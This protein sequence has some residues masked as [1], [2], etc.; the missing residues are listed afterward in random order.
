MTD[1]EDYPS[2]AVASSSPAS[3]SGFEDLETIIPREEL[4]A[5]TPNLTNLTKEQTSILLRVL[6]ALNESSP[7]R[8]QHN[9]C[10][11][12][13]R[14]T[15]KMVHGYLALVIC[16]LGV[17]ANIL[18]MIIFTRREMINSTNT[19]LT[20]LAVA[21]FLVL[22]EYTAFAASYIRGHNA[23]LHSHAHTCYILFH[24]H[25]AQVL[26]T[27][28]ICLTV[29]LAVWRYIA[30]CKPHLNLV[31]CTLPRAKIVV[32]AAYVASPL[33]S[34]P[35]AFMYT[36]NHVKEKS[37]NT[38]L[39]YVDFSEQAKA[40][41]GLLHT[42][43]FWCYSVVIKLLPCLLLSVLIFHIIRAMYVAKRRKETL[44]NLSSPSLENER[45]IP[46]VEKLTEKTTRMLLTVLLMFLAT[47]LPQGILALLS[48]IY[49]RTFF[50]KCYLHWGEVMD[51]LA[52][53]N[54]AANFILYYILSHQF[55]VA[56]RG[57]LLKKG[58]PLRGS[59]ARAAAAGDTVSTQL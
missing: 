28:A 37:S 24:A 16:V 29:T 13:F 31:L 4:A 26:H 53:I 46:R 9:M 40:R 47:E 11:V 25:F 45:K 14:D 50:R 57:L 43:T 38:T 19:L 3:A 7:S 30:I 48:G 33:L 15:Y 56:C 42:I 10:D 6:N 41:G 52:L 21:D 27:V 22:L 55:R 20:G 8:Q 18:N 35:N 59:Q 49:G 54:S 32:V 1:F 58:R 36:I 17:I 34:I 39:Y 5:L 51:L 23:L 2:V 44:I 12:G